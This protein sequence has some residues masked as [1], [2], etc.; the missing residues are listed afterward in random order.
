MFFW[1]ATQVP[2]TFLASLPHKCRIT[3][4]LDSS[5][6]YSLMTYH[7]GFLLGLIFRHP[8][9]R[10]LLI[11]SIQWHRKLKY[12]YPTMH[13]FLKQT[14]K[15][16]QAAFYTSNNFQRCRF[17]CLETISGFFR[18]LMSKSIIIFVTLKSRFRIKVTKNG[19][20]LKLTSV[21]LLF[22]LSSN[23]HG[24]LQYRRY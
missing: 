18:C 1:T 23:F 10:M 9:C 21:H 14:S 13:K 7:Q 4:G 22:G 5:T 8:E 12:W 20:T 6:T 15:S 3:N 17:L 24:L 16:S 2:L 11:F 19:G